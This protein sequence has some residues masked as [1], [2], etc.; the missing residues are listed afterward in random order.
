M[1]PRE[2][3]AKAAAELAEQKK[4]FLGF[5]VKRNVGNENDSVPPGI[6]TVAVLAVSHSVMVLVH[7]SATKMTEVFRQSCDLVKM[8]MQMFNWIRE[9]H[10]RWPF[11]DQW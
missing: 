2:I 8:G 7:M 9:V 1:I 5:V 6:E 3:D 4:K 10:S 11:D